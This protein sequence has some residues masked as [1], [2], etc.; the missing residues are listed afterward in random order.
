MG[1]Q[2]INILIYSIIISI[3]KG[4]YLKIIS[5]LVAFSLCF[6]FYFSWNDLCIYLF[7]LL[8]KVDSVEN[9]IP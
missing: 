5:K 7:V 9:D 1:S 2:Y 8:T 4:H 3:L 6:L